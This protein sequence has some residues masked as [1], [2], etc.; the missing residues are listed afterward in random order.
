MSMSI[1]QDSFIER[2]IRNDRIC[3]MATD[4]SNIVVPTDPR[5]D[6]EVILKDDDDPQF[7]IVEVL[8]AGIISKTNRRRYNNNNIREIAKL[9]VGTQGFY[10]H[11]D[12]SKTGFEFRE[13][14]SI[15]VG[16]IVDHMNDG[17]DRCIMKTYLF[18]DSKLREWI[19]KSIAAGNPMTVS[20]DAVA[21]IMR[22][23]N[24]DVIDVVH[25]SELLSV[26]WANPGTEGVDTAKALE[27][28]QELRK[29]GSNMGMELNAQDIIRNVTIAELRAYNPD[30][31]KGIIQ[32]VTVA[33]L[34]EHN[35][36]VVDKIISDNQLT[37]VDLTID[38]KTET[39]KISEM[40]STVDAYEEKIKSLE[41][42]IQQSKITEMRTRLVSENVPD[43]YREKILPRITGN[44]EDEIKKSIES[45][46][47]YIQEMSGN[48]DFGNNKPIGR[49]GNDGG[50]DIKASVAAMFGIKIEDDK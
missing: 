38:G 41:G 23:L 4:D 45:E 12:P 30:G 3:E 33:E 13:P 48:Q 21:D 39:V 47:S 34:Q 25:I 49:S 22:N 19:P 17:L 11:R 9:I 14:Q 42:E 40:Q 18:K 43:G 15:C 26:D 37:S 44:T 16:A 28:V 32:N 46:V 5:I 29:G 24:S 8:R 1:T 7:V 27:V 10:G 6:M 36:G 31:Y 20:I 50:D 2:M 35:K